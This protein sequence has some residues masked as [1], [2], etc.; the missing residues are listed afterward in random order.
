MRFQTLHRRCAALVIAG[1]CVNLSMPA[2]SATPSFLCSKA[3]SWVEKTICASDRLSELDMDLA[4]EY[5]RML[6][7]LSSDAEKALNTE[8]RKWWAERGTCQKQPDPGACLE[9]RY[10][11]RITE[12]TGRADYPGDQPRPRE[13]FSEA[14][15]K[16]AGKGWS[17]H[18]SQYMKAIRA[19]ISKT[20]PAPRAV[21]T[22]WG[23][24]EGELIAMRL[25][26]AAGEDLVCV[27]KKDGTQANVRA[28]E[29]VETLPDAGPVL[30]LGTAGAPKEA[31]GK[32]VQVIDTDDTPVGWLAEASC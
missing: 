32:P 26:G 17:Q 29:A 13:E 24:E 25:R 1:A 27:A 6:K 3:K 18:A 22:A 5:A 19:C 31:C 4:T 2:Q 11:A 30:W 21:L 15:I 16:E 8:Q 10:Q 9:K 14:L 7:V 12:L 28:R 20:K 23:E